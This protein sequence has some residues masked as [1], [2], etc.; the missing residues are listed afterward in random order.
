MPKHLKNIKTA[1]PKNAPKD[2]IQYLEVFYDKVPADERLRLKAEE[3]AVIAKT[4]FEMSK[5]RKVGKPEIRFS[6]P[7]KPSEDTS[8]N[9]TIVDIVQEDMAFIVDSVVAEVVRHK[10]TID[11]LIHPMLKIKKSK[12]GQIETKANTPD[13]TGDAESHMHIKLHGILTDIQ[14]EELEMG[15]RN[16]L[17][18]VDY[19]TKDWLI[20]RE[21]LREAQKTLVHAPKQYSDAMVEEYQAFLEYMYD[22]NFTLLGYREY[23][24]AQKDRKLISSTVKGKSLGLLRDEIKPI[25]INEARAGL[26]QAQQKMRKGQQPITI[27]KS[28]KRSTV[29]RRVPL[30][31]IAVKIFDKKGAVAGEMMFIGLFTSVTYSRSII[32]IPYL[33][34]K[35]AAVL[36]RAQF[37][38]QS[39]DSKAL[40]HILEKYPRDELF[41]I[42]DEALYKHAISILRLQERPRIALY[43]RPDPF[44]RYISCLVYVPRERYDTR[45]RLTFI[46]ILEEELGGRCTNFKVTQ[47]DS[48]LSRVIFLIDINHL[49]NVPKFNEDDLEIKLM[50]AGRVWA[51]RLKNALDKTPENEETTAQIIQTFGR[52][53]PVNYHERYTPDEAIEDIQKIQQVIKTQSI[54]LKLYQPENC[55]ADKVRLKCYN[56]AEPIILSD[57]LPILEHMGLKILAELP[58]EIKPAK[59]EE[60]IW[61]HDFLMD[62]PNKSH[63]I[64]VQGIKEVFEEALH[65][66]LCGDMEDDKL[67]KLILRAQMPW[68]HI[69]LLRAY[70]SYMRQ[71]GV[72]FSRSY[73]ERALTTHP[74]IASA[75]VS[76]F[77]NLLNPQKQK[78]KN[79]AESVAE[80]DHLMEKVSSLDFDRILRSFTRLVRATLRTNFYQS[81]K[82]GNPKSHISLKMDSKQIEELP[83]PKPYREIFVHSPYVEGI[84]LRGDIIARGGI[85]WSDRHEDFRTEVLGLMKAQMVKNAVIVPMGAKGG[86]VVK[87]P[88]LEQ[89]PQA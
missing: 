61:I 7:S 40:K 88:P 27:S 21:K 12:S 18:D 70:V 9:I 85:R 20:M 86:F 8:K 14:V 68:R 54:T 82:N 15:L 1:L 43:T 35:T 62:I 46:K 44:G 55:D 57:I 89:G 87:N 19:A 2:L 6:R 25:Y 31:V 4:H 23:K 41:Q 16:V 79:K 11:F 53:F 22:N 36:D 71:T 49:Q 38:P 63:E 84:H 48:P 33:R 47:D 66:I 50:E 60:S 26:T 73:I 45:L 72:P 34:M 69:S 3:G 83:E 74:D 64:S 13:N 67:N 39:H 30:D 37:T 56:L 32:D 81:D 65:K 51:D 28:N 58:Y 5:K 78:K 59:A 75:I 17:R 42:T 24:F 52:A 76:L 77:E 80:I 10:H 29:H